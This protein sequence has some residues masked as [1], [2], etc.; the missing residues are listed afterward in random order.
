MENVKQF[1][2]RAVREA[3]TTNCDSL[4]RENNNCVHIYFIGFSGEIEYINGF[5]SIIRGF[6]KISQKMSTFCI[7]NP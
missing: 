4:F 2:Q 1:N 7:E 6:N 5:L 3:E